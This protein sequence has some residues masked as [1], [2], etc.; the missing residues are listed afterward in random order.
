[1]GRRGFIAV[2]EAVVFNLSGRAYLRAARE[3]M[4]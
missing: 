2:D 4:L 3:V 1:V